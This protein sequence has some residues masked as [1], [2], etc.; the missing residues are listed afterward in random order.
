M[1]QNHDDY[2]QPLLPKQLQ[3]VDCH[4][5]MN[6]HPLEIA[7]QL[8]LLHEHLFHNITTMDMIK[9]LKNEKV[10]DIEAEIAFSN[11]V[12]PWCLPSTVFS[13]Q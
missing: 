7:R 1:D 10:P 8:T 5:F 6:I 13:Q 9:Q 4:D 11:R 3:L 12:L 2:P